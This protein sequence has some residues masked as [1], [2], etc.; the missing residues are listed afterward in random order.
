MFRIFY[1]RL[2]SSS[3]IL[4]NGLMAAMEMNKDEDG[5]K[6]QKNILQS[7][8]NPYAHIHVILGNFSIKNQFR[9]SRLGL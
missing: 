8:Q 3:I 1:T 2:N 7:F 5:T 4:A 9:Y 6:R